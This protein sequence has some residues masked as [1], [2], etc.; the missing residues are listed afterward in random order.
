MNTND[1]FSKWLPVWKTTEYWTGLQIWN[2][3][4]EKSS[5]RYLDVQYSEDQNSEH[6]N[7]ITSPRL[8]WFT[9]NTDNLG[10]RR[11]KI[12]HAYKRYHALSGDWSVAESCFLW[13]KCSTQAALAGLYADHYC[14]VFFVHIM[15]IFIALFVLPVCIC[16]SFKLTLIALSPV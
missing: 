7:N 13:N 8:S 12:W 5:F 16:F 9:L 15:T 4:T 2:P 6:L 3:H 1:C 11:L 14:N 10:L